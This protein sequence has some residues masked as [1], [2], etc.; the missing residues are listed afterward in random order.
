M[1]TKTGDNKIDLFQVLKNQK[2]ILIM[3]IPFVIWL[4][5]FRYIPIWGWI[6]GF[7][8][9]QPGQPVKWVGFAHFI[10]LFQEPRFYLALRNTFVM[11]VLNLFSGTI[12]AITFALF[13][14]EIKFGVFKRTVQTV[15]YLPYF[16]S[17]VIVASIFT[18]LLALSGPV[19][20]LLVHLKLIKAPVSFFGEK[21]YFWWIH[22][23]I[24]VWKNTGWNAIIYLAAISG[25]NPELYEAA[26]IDGAGRFRRMWHITIPGILPVVIVILIMN[27]GWLINSGFE[28]QF[29]LKNY[30]VIENAEVLDLYVIDYG[31]K[32][33][34]YSYGTAIGIFKSVVSIILV[35]VANRLARKA[36]VSYIF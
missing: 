6:M 8:E 26:R 30:L 25:I 35:I 31:I 20:E 19:N 14:N 3:S 18:K 24:N 15:S 17:W 29:L 12:A 33:S 1:K 28:S 21:E 36:S 7:Q 16:V 10:K 5:I 22:A 11:S 2:Y 13:L 27:I 4:I 9:F 23:A 32:L 34:R